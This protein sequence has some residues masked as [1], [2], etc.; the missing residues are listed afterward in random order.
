MYDGSYVPGSMY[1]LVILSVLF[2]LL[3]SQ[4][5]CLTL[6][7]IKTLSKNLKYVPSPSPPAPSTYFVKMYSFNREAFQV[8]CGQLLKINK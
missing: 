1:V 2:S 3:A 4:N 6:T 7:C 5:G 8:Q